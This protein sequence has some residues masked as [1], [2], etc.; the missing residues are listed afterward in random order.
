MSRQ[1]VGLQ[2]EIDDLVDDWR[3]YKVYLKEKMI[4]WQ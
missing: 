3:R 4:H 1:Q 2:R